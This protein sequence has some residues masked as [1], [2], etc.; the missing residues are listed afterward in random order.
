MAHQYLCA[1]SNCE[2]QQLNLADVTIPSVI[3]GLSIVIHALAH[4]SSIQLRTRSCKNVKQALFFFAFVIFALPS[5]WLS[6]ML[7][8]A[9]SSDG[10]LFVAVKSFTSSV[11]FADSSVY[12]FILRSAQSRHYADTSLSTHCV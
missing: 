7:V 11:Q 6:S 2:V 9:A 10:N 12:S 5:L 1:P 4:L 3:L 8:L